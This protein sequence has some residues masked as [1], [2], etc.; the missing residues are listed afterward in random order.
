MTEQHLSILRLLRIGG[1]IV[2]S[3]AVMGIGIYILKAPLVWVA[4][5]ACLFAII[6][7]VTMT[8]LLRRA[9]AS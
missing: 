1:P 3:L 4:V 7:W 9:E 5:F 6:E 2:M 8:W